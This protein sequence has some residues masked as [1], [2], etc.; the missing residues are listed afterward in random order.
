ML[1]ILFLVTNLVPYTQAK[2]CGEKKCENAVAKGERPPTK[3]KFTYD[4]ISNF[5]YLPKCL[6]C[7]LDIGIL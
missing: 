7:I 1:V 4:I 2:A 6:Q 3:S 5:F